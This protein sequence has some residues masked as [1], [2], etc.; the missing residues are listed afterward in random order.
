MGKIEKLRGSG[1]EITNA[2]EIMA[3]K[4]NEL[5][6]DLNFIVKILADN[7]FIEPKTQEPERKEPDGGW[8][9]H[10]FE[11][12]RT[13]EEIERAL[14]PS[15]SPEARCEHE[16]D[17]AR[18]NWLDKYC[19][20]V[21]DSQFNIGPYKVGELRKMADDGIALEKKV[22]SCVHCQDFPHCRK[23]KNEPFYG[24]LG[25]GCSNCQCDK[26]V[27]GIRKA[28][29]ARVDWEIF[30][31][32]NLEDIFKRRSS[33]KDGRHWIDLVGLDKELNSIAA[34]FISDAFEKGREEG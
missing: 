3:Q 17:T 2:C 22:G 34:K 32:H 13:N 33:W 7:G 5:V 29:E 18:L 19:S 11:M 26:T 21:A 1:F 30:G 15:P 24:V 4:I 8:C 31:Q 20:F 10:K 9:D 28:P 12:I 16:N 6:D 27:K 25:C 14:K 23:E